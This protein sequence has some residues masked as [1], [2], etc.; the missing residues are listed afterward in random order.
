MSWNRV[1]WIGGVARSG[2]SWL[3][4]MINSHESVRFRFQPLFSY[5]FKARVNEDSTQ[6]Q[7]LAFLKELW[8]TESEFLVQQDKID[9]G[10]YPNFE[11]N[12]CNVLAFKENRYLSVIEPM[13]RRIEQM[14]FV[15]IVRNPCAVINS[16]CKNEK[17]FPAGSVLREQWRFGACKNSGS[18]DYFGYYKW[19]EAANSFLDLA[20][21]YPDRACVFSYSSVVANPS[22]CVARILEMLDLEMTPQVQSFI[23]SSSSRHS[24]NY[25]SV[26][27]SAAKTSLDWQNELDP[28]IVDEIHADLRSTRLEQFLI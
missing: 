25:Y 22:K 16:W 9:A 8:E 19:K 1:L 3:A 14:R 18:E 7:H 23:E 27:K 10:E 11:K 6:Q 4:Q 12:N 24:N 21:Q 20:Q 15:G 28:Y 5:E 26:Y 2:T 13:L 17:E